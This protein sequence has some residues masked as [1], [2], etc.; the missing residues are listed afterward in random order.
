MRNRLLTSSLFTLV[1]LTLLTASAPPAAAQTVVLF[2]GRTY[3]MGHA[4]VLLVPAVVTGNDY[5]LLG[6]LE[7]GVT[8]HFNLFAHLGGEF[9]GGGTALAG[10]GWMATLHRQ[11]DALPLNIGLFNSWIFPLKT[12]GPDAFITISPV[13]SHRFERSTGSALVPYGGLAAILKIGS[14]GTDVNAVLGLKVERI[15][16]QWDFI[17]ELQ[18]GEKSQFA[19]GFFYR[20]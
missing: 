19:L 8:D 7:Y 15:A 20:F 1:T 17:A 12:A 18:A 13:L 3:D 9:N 4:R 6:R 14:P 16:A 5:G 10:A 2:D 11:S